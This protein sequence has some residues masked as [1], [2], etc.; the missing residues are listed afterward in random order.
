MRTAAKLLG[1]AAHRNH[2]HILLVFLAEKRH[3]ARFL[4]L[5]QIHNLR[6]YR[7]RR[8]DLLIY[9]SFHFFKLRRCHSLKMRKIKTQTIR[10]HQRTLLLHMTA[11]NRL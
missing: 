5:L 1:E 10:C 8:L 3:S 11:K 4:G 7:K 9:Q 6:H 2:A